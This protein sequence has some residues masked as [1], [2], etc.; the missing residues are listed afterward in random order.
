MGVQASEF[1]EVLRNSLRAVD[2]G[3]CSPESFARIFMW[4]YADLGCI[5]SGLVSTKLIYK[6]LPTAKLYRNSVVCEEHFQTRTETMMMIVDAHKK[7]I[8]DELYLDHLMEEGS[9]VHLV[10]TQENI[11]L[12]KFQSKKSTAYI[13]GWEEQYKAANIVLTADPGTFGRKQ[14]FYEIDGTCYADKYEAAE[15]L[16]IKVSTV[17]T[18]S[19]NANKFPEWK[20]HK[21]TEDQFVYEDLDADIQEISYGNKIQS[22]KA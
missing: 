12:M 13:E 21:Y 19:R 9:K 14:Y 15:C 22:V 6:H 18:R 17:I 5:H 11:D 3:V 10:T 4:S 16:D 2:N 7:N 20:E 8:L 1:K